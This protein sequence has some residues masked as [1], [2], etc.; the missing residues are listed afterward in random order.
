MCTYGTIFVVPQTA[1]F[2]FNILSLHP[3]VCGSNWLN[4]AHSRRM[5]YSFTCQVYIFFKNAS[6][7]PKSTRTTAQMVLCN[8]PSDVSGSGC[9]QNVQLVQKKRKKK[10][11]F[12]FPDVF[13]FFVSLSLQIFSI[14]F[15]LVAIKCPQNDPLFSVSEISEL[16][17]CRDVSSG[18]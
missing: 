16:D 13:L 1:T 11:K 17:E 2:P 6:L 9:W 4:L 15:H 5:I 7:F 8:K 14:L 10:S 12:M 18:E 3:Q